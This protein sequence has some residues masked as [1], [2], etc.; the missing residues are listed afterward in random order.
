MRSLVRQRAGTP[1]NGYRSKS[2][3]PCSSQCD[4]EWASRWVVG[5]HLGVGAAVVLELRLTPGCR[6]PPTPVGA[7]WLA[8][9]VPVVTPLHASR[10]AVGPSG[11]R[12]PQSYSNCGG[13]P[14]LSIPCR[15][16][17]CSCLSP[18]GHSVR[19]AW[20]AATAATQI[21]KS[22]S[23]LLSRHGFVTGVSKVLSETVPNLSD[24]WFR[25]QES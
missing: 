18:S 10:L 17:C 13:R 2:L 22:R 23:L 11:Q 15:M 7:L 1:G 14:P 6:L 19:F 16:M 12:V 9:D 20:G 8:V 4:G 21:K 3:R 25:R 24:T 5:N